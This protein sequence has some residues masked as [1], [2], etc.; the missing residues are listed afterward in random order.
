MSNSNNPIQDAVRSVELNGDGDLD[1]EQAGADPFLDGEQ[2]GD[3]LDEPAEKEVGF[4]LMRW[5]ERTPEG[6]HHDFDYREWWDP[7][8]G[9]ENRLAFHL[10]D[11]AGAAGSGYPNALGIVVALAEIYWRQV[12]K[13]QGSDTSNSEEDAETSEGPTVDLQTAEQ[14]V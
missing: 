3:F 9:G 7:E 11:A 5:L 1:G 4:S 10:A 13:Q 14:F 8:T 2:A 12:K 6:S